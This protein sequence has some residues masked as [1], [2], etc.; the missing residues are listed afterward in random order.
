[1][2]QAKSSE[3]LLGLDKPKGQNLDFFPNPTEGLVRVSE[4]ISGFVSIYSMN[5][6]LAKCFDADFISEI[7]L[8]ELQNGLYFIRIEMSD[9][10]ETNTKVIKN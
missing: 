10:T 4:P 9:G 5:G 2:I 1:M 7:N 8:A 3:Q 6:Q